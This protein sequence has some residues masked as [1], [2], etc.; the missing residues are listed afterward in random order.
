MCAGKS[1]NAL[2]DQKARVLKKLFLTEN[3]MSM[4]LE[5]ESPF[6]GVQAG[7]FVML[8]TAPGFDPLLG[9]P[10][11]F[12][13]STD[14]V[15]EILVAITGRGTKL[16]SSLPAGENLSIRGPLGNG[17]PVSSVK[18]VICL[19]GGVGIAPFLPLGGGSQDFEFHLGVPGQRWKPLVE[20]VS[21]KV[22]NLTVYSDDGSIGLH[23][24]PLLRL[25]KT[26]PLSESVWAC[27]PNA[28]MKAVGTECVSRGIAAWIS[29]ETRMACGM[30]GCHGC[31]VKTVNGPLRA[32]VDGPVFSV[33]EV[34][35]HDS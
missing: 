1:A 4:T 2:V 26:D 31:V 11:A 5:L 28:M 10:F 3:L 18:K 9:R 20:W 19:A 16:L 13:G 7:Q 24:T 32:C 8:R 22:G 23:G 27:G 29:L 6:R 33:R 35:W 14:N 17:F 34:L 25:E 15:V 30:G 12:C 21:R